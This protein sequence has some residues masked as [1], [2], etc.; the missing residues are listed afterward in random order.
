[1]Q[2]RITNGRTTVRRKFVQRI[3]RKNCIFEWSR[4]RRETIMFFFSSIYVETQSHKNVNCPLLCRFVSFAFCF[5]LEIL[6]W[7]QSKN[8]V[9]LFTSMEMSFNTHSHKHKCP[10]TK[11][12]YLNQSRTERCQRIG[13]FDRTEFEI[14]A[15][16]NTKTNNKNL[17]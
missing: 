14:R 11:Y 2:S 16:T 3:G 10:T 13:T 5:L 15:K 4:A 9:R 8:G 12:K 1:M 17:E 6:H 7:I